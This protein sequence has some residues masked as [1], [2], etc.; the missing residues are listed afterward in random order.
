MCIHKLLSLIINEFVNNIM[1]LLFYLC[2]VF[3]SDNLYLFLNNTI[4][5]Y[6]IQPLYINLFLSKNKI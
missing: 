6:I 1:L 5:I 4:I 3:R 2:T